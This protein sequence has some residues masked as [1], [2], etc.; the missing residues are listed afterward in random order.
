MRTRL[1]QAETLATQRDE[2]AQDLG[3]RLRQLEKNASRLTEDHANAVA[4]LAQAQTLA[5]AAQA[6]TD[7]DVQEIATLRAGVE[8]L[9]ASARQLADSRTALASLE[10]Q[11]QNVTVD[12][13][14]LLTAKDAELGAL[15]TRLAEQQ[16]LQT[17]LE[18]ALE[19]AASSASQTF[20]QQAALRAALEE[21]TVDDIPPEL[22]ARP[23]PAPA[24]AVVEDEPPPRSRPVRGA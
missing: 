7:A 2:E 4:Q 10:R 22:P 8:K 5:A 1:E 13:D 14:T 21:G 23:I 24:K 17:R 3:E 11:L 18:E 9:E 16:A 19:L 6:R 12:R 20:D 15:Q